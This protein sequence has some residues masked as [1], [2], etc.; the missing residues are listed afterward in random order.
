MHKKIAENTQETLIELR[1]LRMQS[2]IPV[3]PFIT[4]EPEGTVAQ[5]LRVGSI[6]EPPAAS[7]LEQIAKELDGFSH[8]LKSERDAWVS[9]LQINTGIVVDSETMGEDEVESIDM[10]I[11]LLQ[12][13]LQEVDQ[14]LERAR[15][16]SKREY[17]QHVVRR[18]THDSG[19]SDMST[20]PNSRYNQHFPTSPIIQA[21]SG[22]PVVRQ[23]SRLSFDGASPIL[24]DHRASLQRQLSTSPLNSPFL[25]SSP[26]TS[27]AGTAAGTAATTPMFTSPGSNPDTGTRPPSI[28]L[29]PAA[30]DWS[31]F[32]NDAQVTCEG[33]Q[34]P[35]SCKISQR[36]RTRDCG[37]SL[38]A[39]RANGSYLDHEIPAFGVAL[40]HTSH[41]GANPQAKNVVTFLE[42]NAHKLKKVTR[43]GES[44]EREPKYIFGNAADHKAFQELIYGC[45][46]EE[47]WDIV[48][49]G[50]DREK[51]CVTQ[52]LRLWRDTHTRIPLILFYTNS[53]RRSA[54]TYI[55]EPSMR[56]LLFGFSSLLLTT[57]LQ[58]PRSQT[59]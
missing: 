52:T 5:E 53:R 19:I 32:C 14:K 35:W 55:Q 29:P 1:R 50:S 48:S 37:L 15:N 34:R 54:K 20:S 17:N 28:R 11:T 23:T 30:T 3:M 31:L 4:E 25:Q 44:P 24:E 7:K 47:S 39:E 38:R 27:Y 58:K 26:P 8:L 41:T 6:A 2:T 13:V 46:L 49:I 12:T 33:W 43:Q 21:P 18:T 56:P 42:A 57:D 51:E 45:D 59:K 40:P 9:Q 22:V 16:S 10:D 36:R